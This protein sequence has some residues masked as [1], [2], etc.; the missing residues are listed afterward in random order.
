MKVT[1]ELEESA[2]CAMISDTCC[3]GFKRKGRREIVKSTDNAFQKVCCKEEQRNREV[4]VEG[5]GGVEIF[6]L[7][8]N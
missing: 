4:V 6:F 1:N 8:V 7:V 5:S 3:H 2:F